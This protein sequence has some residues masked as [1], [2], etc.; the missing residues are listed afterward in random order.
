MFALSP[1]L[2][3]L[4]EV[5]ALVGILLGAL[6]AMFRFAGTYILAPVNR[7]NAEQDLQR[8]NEALGPV[9]DELAT[10]RNEVTYNGGKSL[11]DGVRRIDHRL[12]R[13]EG[14][15]EEHDRWQHLEVERH[16]EG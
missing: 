15:F 14:A 8:L 16:D 10:I 9:H 6:V 13:L 2:Q 12:T 3:T 7:R 5:A 1:W 11:K 4:G